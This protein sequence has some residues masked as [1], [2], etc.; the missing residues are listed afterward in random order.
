MTIVRTGGLGDTILVL[1]TFEILRAAYPAA[2]L[3]LVGSAWA[4]ALQPLVPCGV[5]VLQFDRVFPAAHRGGSEG[6]S[7]TDV[8]AAASA[9]IVYTATP[10]SDF[11]AHVRCA[12]PGP[13]LVWPVAPAEGVHAARHLASAVASVPS[14]PDALPMP[15]LRSPRGLRFRSRWWLDRQFGRGVRPVAVHPGA[16]GRR[17]CWP[18]RRYA[19]LATRLDA[20]VLLVEGPA[21]GDACREFVQVVDPA[22]PVVRAASESL[23]RLAALL[24]ESRGYV[25]NDSGVS[26]LAAALGVPTIAVFGPTDPAVWAPPGP[27]VYAIAPRGDGPWP[28]VDDVLIAARKFPNDRPPGIRA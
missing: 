5:R 2:T 20:P 26:H 7:G 13:V 25:G 16:G 3:T 28:T 12:C 6:G 10:E 22:V 14:D 11:V 18:A 23:P 24:V 15:T 9:V 27:D 1:P 21:D 8:L 17:K 19:D 4:E